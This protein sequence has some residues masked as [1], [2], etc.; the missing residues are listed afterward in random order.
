MIEPTKDAKKKTPTHPT[1]RA[2][3]D[4]RARRR[5]AKSA[6]AKQPTDADAD[7]TQ[8]NSAIQESPGFDAPATAE[9]PD[10]QAAQP[11]TPEPSG[12]PD[13][14]P[15]VQASFKVSLRSPDTEPVPDPEAPPVEVPDAD[16]PIRASNDAR[17]EHQD[18][19]Q[20]S[21]SEDSKD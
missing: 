15:T 20:E 11:G 12:S 18:E 2:S 16:S 4:P 21:G 1:E 9:T 19:A 17:A 6:T 13:D 5:A 14:T 10:A 3:N 8:R 7:T